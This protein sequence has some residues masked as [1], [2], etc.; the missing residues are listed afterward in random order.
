[1][2][3]RAIEA[4]ARGSRKS[5]VAGSSAGGRR[6]CYEAMKE[7]KSSL[8]RAEPFRLRMQLPDNDDTI[9]GGEWGRRPDESSQVRAFRRS[10][11]QLCDWNAQPDFKQIVE[12]SL[13][14]FGVFT[15]VT[16]SFYIKDFLF[17]VDPPHGFRE[18]PTWSRVLIAVA[19]IALL[20][21]YI[22][23]SAVHLNSTYVAKVVTT[24]RQ[25]S[26]DGMPVRMFAVDEAKSMKS[27]RLGWLFFD[28]LMLIAFGMFAV[29]ITYAFDFD[30]I[31]WRSIWF[32][33]VGLGWSGIAA[34][35]RPLDQ[36]IAE[37]W[38]VIDLVQL[39]IM[40]ALL[41][42]SW[43]ATVKAVILAAVN[44]LCLFLDLA[45][46]SRPPPVAA[47]DPAPNPGGANPAADA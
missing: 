46:V 9:K 12:K 36:E 33:L 26:L 23:G 16:L 29:S 40:A 13:T 27:E 39:G 47:A 10:A 7:T 24:I 30:D 35:Y 15:G 45:V 28:M 31:I 38:L 21:R 37:R 17:A 18:F 6:P 19:V 22:I 44:V 32:I 2:P 1:M 20:L 11:M 41:M 25:T 43:P 8:L 3:L 42:F 4:R 14:L 34:L 5:R